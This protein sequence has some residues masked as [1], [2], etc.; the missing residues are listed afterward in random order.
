MSSGRRSC[1]GFLFALHL[2]DL[3][4]KLIDPRAEL[5]ELTDH[6]LDPLCPQTKLLDQQHGPATDA[7]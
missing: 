6:R 1:I 5:L 2:L 3:A 4:A 7:G